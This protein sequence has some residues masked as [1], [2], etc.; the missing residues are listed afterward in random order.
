MM[1]R[2]EGMIGTKHTR[3]VFSQGYREGATPPLVARTS[4][5]SLHFG[6]ELIF[7]ITHSETFYGCQCG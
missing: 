5:D 6:F 1:A 4:S 2:C 3:H 7:M